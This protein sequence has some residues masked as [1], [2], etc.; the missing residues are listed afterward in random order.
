MLF[1]LLC[2]IGSTQL[3]FF[4]R[5]TTSLHLQD[6]WAALHYAACN[7]HLALTGLLI[8]HGADVNATEKVRAYKQHLGMSAPRRVCY[9]RKRLCICDHLA[10]SA[11]W[12]WHAHAVTT[13]CP[14]CPMQANRTALH[15]AARNGHTEVVADLLK[16]GADVNATDHDGMTALHRAASNGNTRA[17]GELIWAHAHVDAKL[18][19][20]HHCDLTCVRSW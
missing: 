10:E 1:V 9:A 18:Q 2:V 3:P 4:F 19:V 7:G 20:T 13:N 8:D 16:A 11:S 17:A 6:T 14:Y 5:A 15:L 12:I